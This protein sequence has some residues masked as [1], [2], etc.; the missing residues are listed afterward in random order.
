MSENEYSFFEDSLTYKL[1][2]KSLISRMI[3]VC[4][5]FLIVG[6]FIIIL[7]KRGAFST[8]I[9]YNFFEDYAN[10]YNLFCILIFNYFMRGSFIN[11]FK[12]K[13]KAISNS[14]KKD[15]H[16][17]FAG[18]YI[19]SYLLSHLSLLFINNA[20]S[21]GERIWVNYLSNLEIVLYKVL[22]IYIWATII[23]LILIISYYTYQLHAE[24]KSDNIKVEIEHIDNRCG[25]KGV[26][27]ALSA[28]I[29]YG[30]VLLMIIAV[31]IISDQRA[32]ALYGL[33]SDT[34]NYLY[35]IVVTAIIL[36]GLYFGS[37][38]ISYIVIKNH[39]RQKIECIYNSGEGNRDRLISLYSFHIDT[40]GILTFILTV[41]FPIVIAII[42][43]SGLF[44]WL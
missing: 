20:E 37:I 12:K 40:K 2:K 8:E 18:I 43:F 11:F 6:V 25:L 24:A 27:S 15:K 33:G 17:I 23:Q 16:Y 1:W 10:S 26:F 4:I 38:I 5:P 22:I 39:M 34:N 21:Y 7:Y 32:K 19:F 44:S 28:S 30:V 31:E 42:Q 3:Y 13:I 14:D 35:I 36:S 29:G 9:E 41:I